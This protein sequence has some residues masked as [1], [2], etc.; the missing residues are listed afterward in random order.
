M[1]TARYSRI[2]GVFLLGFLIGACLLA[3]G[4]GSETS[5]TSG[6]TAIATGGYHTCEVLSVGTVQCWGYNESGQ[7]G[8][9]STTRS[10]LPV[11]VSNI[12]TAIAIAAGGDA[13]D[14]VSHTCALLS[15][16]TIQCWGSNSDGQLGNGSTTNSNVPVTVLGIP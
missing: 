2:K 9:G 14:G 15:G 4:C 13:E 8:N 16:G 5:G 10:S 11:P 3:T 12:T 1:K 7:L 6:A